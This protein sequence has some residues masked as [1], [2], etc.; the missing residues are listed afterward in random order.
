MS[1]KYTRGGTYKSRNT[2]EIDNLRQ[3]YLARGDFS[4]NYDPNTDS[5]YQDYA[6]MMRTQGSLAMEDA[7]GKAA[8][9][10]GGYG[11]SYAQTIGQQTYQNYANDI[12]AAQSTFEDRAYDRALAK[13]NSEENSILSKMGMLED[14]ESADKAAWEEDYLNDYNKAVASGITADVA[15]V[16]GMSEDDY[17]R[18]HAAG[19]T[20]LGDEQIAG[21]ASYILNTGKFAD[22]DAYGALEAQGYNMTNVEALLNA[23]AGKNDLGFSVSKTGTDEDGNNIYGVNYEGKTNSSVNSN[24]SGLDT[25][26]EGKHFKIN[27]SDGEAIDVQIGTAV[28]SANNQKIYNIA[29]NKGKGIVEYGGNMYYY[30]G[31]TVYTVVPYSDLITNVTNLLP[32]LDWLK[33]AQTD[34]D[35]AELLKY[36]K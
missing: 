31:S 24:I 20:P 1:Y 13:F 9:S 17:K 29:K 30:D 27:R 10:T 22:G 23:Y 36:F 4:F 35:Y 16:L 26:K 15:A 21:L 12:S 8:A 6:K 2:E 11:N 33:W 32:D 18:Q 5:A 19:L 34:D 14:R 7:M 25:V 3:K 28:D